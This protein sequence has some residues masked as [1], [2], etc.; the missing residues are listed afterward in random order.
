MSR[1]VLIEAGSS[2]P[3]AEDCGVLAAHLC[4]ALG[5]EPVP[6]AGELSNTDPLAVVT[7]SEPSGP[8]GL[9][10]VSP[11]AAALID[12][13]RVP[14]AIAPRG[15]AAEPDGGWLRIGVGFAGAEGSTAALEF[16]ADLAMASHATLIVLTVGDSTTWGYRAA[17]LPSVTEH[18]RQEDERARETLWLGHRRVPDAV[19]CGIGFRRGE[20]REELRS[21]AAHLDLLLLG[22]EAHEM[23][24]GLAPIGDLPEAIEG[25]P[26]PVMVV[27]KKRGSSAENAG[28]P[29]AVASVVNT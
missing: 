28:R 8:D 24:P 4:E 20:A 6:W 5:A 17:G 25:M 19:R 27:P 14:I 21:A 11:T 15:Y 26:A 1:E 13:A 10:H 2:D 7:A 16:A 22:A 23:R 29:D 3:D 12:A 9:I 18:L